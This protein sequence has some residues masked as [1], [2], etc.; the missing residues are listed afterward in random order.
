MNA[1]ISH[2][3]SPNRQ[4]GVCMPVILHPVTPKHSCPIQSRFKSISV[5]ISIPIPHIRPMSH[6]DL[7]LPASHTPPSAPHDHTLGLWNTHLLICRCI[8]QKGTHT[9]YHTSRNNL[10]LQYSQA[11]V[12]WDY[13]GGKPARLESGGERTHFNGVGKDFGGFCDFQ[14]LAVDW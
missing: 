12:S 5:S 10:A 8:D 2:H 4:Y 14:Q 9:R 11:R 6:L 1:T 3:E 13:W 7:P